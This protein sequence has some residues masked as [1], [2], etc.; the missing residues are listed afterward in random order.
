MNKKS[1]ISFYKSIT[2][3]FLV[4]TFSVQCT[5]ASKDNNTQE[6]IRLALN[7]H[8]FTLDTQ[9]TVKKVTATSEQKGLEASLMIDG[10]RVS[11]FNSRFGEITQ[12]PFIISFEFDG[13]E[14]LEY[15]IHNSRHDSGNGW[16]AFGKFEL[17]AATEDTPELTKIGDYDFKQRPFSS[18]L[19]S[20]DTPLDKITK[21][22][23]RIL[24]AYMNRVSCG[25]MTFY[26]ASQE[27]QID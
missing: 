3:L 4:F 21:L 5:G 13:K 2:I 23:F 24:S 15:L 7:A 8:P 17:W 18:S 25:E 16:G 1:L 6:N 10:D 12:W 26:T 9:L 20:F 22:E 19:I 14:N 27:Q 11:Y